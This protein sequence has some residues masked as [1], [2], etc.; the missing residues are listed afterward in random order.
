MNIQKFEDF[1]E[2]HARK[3]PEETEG[4]RLKRFWMT[5]VLLLCLVCLL[6]LSASADS[7]A[8]RV[9]VYCTVNVDG[10]CLVSMSVMLHLEE[11]NDTLTFPLPANATGITMN[12]TAVTPSKTSSAQNVLLT[13][14][15]GGATGD[16]SVRFEY[17]L[18]SVVNVVAPESLTDEP[19]LRLDLPLLCGFSYP[20]QSLTYTITLPKTISTQA[21]FTSTY[22]QAALESVLSN[23]IS[24]NMITG[25]TTAALNDHEAVSMYMTVP[26]DMF[27]TISTYLRTGNP[28]VVPMLAL[29]GA[30]LL[31]W[32]IFLRTAPLRRERSVLPM[33][34]L[35]AGEI[36]CRLTL[37]GGDLTMMVLSWAQMG[38]LIISQ[39]GGRILLHK[40]M[41]MGNERS[42]FEVRTFQALFG[43]RR[44]VD[45]TGLQYAKLR[46][47]TAEMVP[48]EKAM[49]KGGN[50]KIMRLLCCVSQVFCGI[51]LV[52]NLS[53]MPALQ[54]LLCIVVGIFALVSAWLMQ[55]AAYDTHMRSKLKIWIALGCI[56]V[57][58]ILGIVS[59]QIGIALGE[60]LAQIV[61]G[62]FAA[63]GGRRSS[64]NRHEVGLI[65]GLRSYLK[66]VPA[67]DIPQLMESDPDYF[68]RMAPYALAMG[69]LKP[70]AAGFGKRKLPQCPYLYI[71]EPG[72]RTAA[73]WAQLLTQVADRMDARYRQ[74]Q[75]ERW[76]G[77]K[78]R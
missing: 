40:R 39:Q 16:F 11:A 17:T 7:N 32:L 57:W 76:L 12:G 33:D 42:L 61:M 5:A 64:L 15:T 74:I 53:L 51:C 21:H 18:P 23:S 24:G 73:E 9:D 38:Y 20:V 3:S 47:K 36:G 31:Y 44:V 41:D 27:P 37:T 26:N 59:G 65:L 66:K 78:L 28:E 70:F 62:F 50:P 48:G 75:R 22:R 8:S 63:Y 2:R 46:K 56:A 77:V 43:S 35:T 54:V 49:S 29:L 58:A 45:C 69:V 14:A 68:F 25:S 10:D 60:C 34:S 71:K 67:K 19:Y 6:P 72:R 55:A 30:A 1:S 13:R 4:S 52:M